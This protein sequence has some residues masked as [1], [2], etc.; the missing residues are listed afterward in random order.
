MTC[1]CAC[2]GNLKE[3][4]D[5]KIKYEKEKR[6]WMGMDDGYQFFQDSAEIRR[7]ASKIEQAR[8]TTEQFNALAELSEIVFRYQRHYL[9]K[10][11]RKWK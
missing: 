9:S 11:R 2:C 10:L 5:L 7:L 3:L 1:Q 6:G 8:L 4:V